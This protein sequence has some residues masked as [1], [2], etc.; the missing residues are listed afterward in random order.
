MARKRS[1]ISPLGRLF[2]GSTA[3]VYALD[4]RRRI[5]YC[6]PACA[7]WLGVDL[8]R[9]IG[10]T[11]DYH[12][13]SPDGSSAQ[14]AAGL[15]PPP[16]LFSQ[17]EQEDDAGFV[18]R[19]DDAGV[20]SRRRARFLSLPIAGG[21]GGVLVIVEAAEAEAPPP[22]TA[23]D[24]VALHRR[25]WELRRAIGAKYELD[26]LVGDSPAMRRVQEQV[27][28][29][30]AGNCRTVVLGPP[31]SGRE[32]VARTIH[33]RGG[34]PSSAPLAPLACHLLD[35]ELLDSTIVSFVASCAELETEHPA[36]L[37][38]LEVDQMPAETQAALAGV[39]SIGELAVRTLAT[40]Q[41]SLLELA[42][43]GHFRSDLA[44]ALSTLVIEIPPL[45]SRP[46]DVRLL[47]QL[48]LEQANAGATRQFSGF[49]P[50]ALD[51]L[52]AYPWPNNV[53]ELQSVI[54]RAVEVAHGIRINTR[55]LPEEIRHADRAAARPD[56]PEE[57]IVLDDFLLEVEAE[58]LRRAMRQ[59]KGNKAQA[60]R[61]LGISRARVIR[62]CEQLGI[63]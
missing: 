39:L 56:R 49:D 6:N 44:F 34:Q 46:G 45:A 18:H 60:A 58:L 8:G 12:S 17:E 31:G 43:E 2:A 13:G 40:A 57:K 63:E 28:V 5:V 52:A 59:A 50:E 37:L 4:E 26:Q 36:A 53:D 16:E 38:L 15:C 7:A 20:L 19:V 23:A 29:A 9:V 32:H 41:R 10:L 21:S 42:D 33:Y 22:V 27:K 61:L 14:I 24:P 47:A 30:L 54:R 51:L 55:D 25:L 35:A 62:R 11:C 1:N 3:P 48:F